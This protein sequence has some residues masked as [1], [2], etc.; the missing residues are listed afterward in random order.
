MDTNVVH[1][2]RPAQ[3]RPIPERLAMY[4]RV[5]RN[6]HREMLDLIATGERGILGFVIE[7]QFVGRHHELITEARNRGIDLILDPKT[8]PMGLP[9]GHT[10]LLAALPWGLER[11]HNLSD[12]D[13]SQ[14]R[15][16]AAQIVELAARNGF[17]QILGPTHL[18]SG[19][20]DP[21]LRRDIL[22]MEWTREAITAL[23]GDIGL[24]YSLAMP[25]EV[26]RKRTQREALIAAI[27]D[28][29]CDAIWLKV[30]NFGDDATGEKTAAYIEACGDFHARNIPVI[31]DHVGGL[32]GLGA[33]AFGS[34]G[35]I[36]HGVTVQQG[37][38]AARWRRS[39][40]RTGGGPIRRVYLPQLDMLVKPSIASALLATSIRIRARYGC[41]DTHC[42][43]NGINDMVN[44]PARHALYQRA[45][46]VEWL[47]DTPQTMRVARYLDERVRL[48]SD[49]VVA[50]AGI[51]G[52]DDAFQRSLHRK[53]RHMSRF[54]QTMVHLSSV[55]PLN[56]AAIPPSQRASRVRHGE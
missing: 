4:V 31:G 2:P 19:P 20:S 51:S 32:P 24:I 54:R 52:L 50:A 28:A 45:R 34:V 56:T 12:F 49:N 43:P 3:T 11:H 35:G 40:V 47:S 17:A 14:G 21:W 18:L 55:A 23:G 36:A 15:S 7:A 42:C 25:M 1:L 53:Q 16:K 8:Q 26:L 22:M 27:G 33:L 41:R 46:E 29:P 37:F 38:K 6:D 39:S 30:D 5:G 9:G 48:V 13:G 10:A 44:R